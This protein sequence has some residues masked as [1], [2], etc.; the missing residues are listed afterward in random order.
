MAKAKV[1]TDWKSTL[2]RFGFYKR[3]QGRLTR[4]LTAVGITT[5][6]FLGCWT[7]SQHLPHGGTGES[8]QEWFRI[9]FPTFLAALGGW[10][11]FRVVN[12]PRFADFLIAVEVEMAKVT[13]IG[14]DEIVRST[15]VVIS[16]MFFFG[17]VLFFYDM[18]WQWFFQFT[19][20]LQIGSG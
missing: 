13:W 16:T 3:N 12:F 20:F 18:F 9:A 7:L 5:L 17:A 19:G 2:F 15:V 10:I 6:V 14:K 8:G 1:K 4:Q 11:A